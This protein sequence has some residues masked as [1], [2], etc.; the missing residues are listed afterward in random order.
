MT[1]QVSFITDE[2]LKNKALE[3]AKEEGLTLK[4][5]LVYAMKGFVEGKI[6]F[7]IVTTEESEVEEIHFDNEEIQTKAKRLAKL[8]A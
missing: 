2:E 8:L 7:G 1:T 4:T 5:V 6:K 3:R